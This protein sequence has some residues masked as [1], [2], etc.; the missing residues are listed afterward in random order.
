MKVI[1]IEINGARVN[2]IGLESD[3]TNI[4]QN[5]EI[6]TFLELGDD[7][8][9]EEVRRFKDLLHTV[10]SGFSPD[11]IGIYTKS[12]TGKF[13][14]GPLTYKIEG[15]IQ[16][17]KGKDMRFVDPRSM[18]ALKR[19]KGYETKCQ[20]AYQQKAADVAYYLIHNNE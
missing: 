19:K 5:R 14:A 10:F 16:L 9:F 6:S 15:L 2:F 4:F 17:Y 1:G 7:K 12:A 20:F 3:S 18:A 8:D 13:S 11:I